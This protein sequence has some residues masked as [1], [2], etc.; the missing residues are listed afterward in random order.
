M[1][2]APPTEA[3]RR[4]SPEVLRAA[5]SSLVVDGAAVWEL[6]TRDLMVAM[7][8]YHHCARELGVS[9]P[10]L[11]DELAASAPVALA[12]TVRAFGRHDDVTPAAFGFELVALEDGPAY[13]WPNVD[14][15]VADRL[16][17]YLEKDGEP[18]H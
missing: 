15:D 16:K 18:D 3:L 17:L 11:F 5:L 1:I 9:V 10:E 14:R 2:D 6:D 8:P 4:G 7:A 13:V 12:E